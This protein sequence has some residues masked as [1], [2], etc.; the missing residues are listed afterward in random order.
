MNNNALLSSNERQGAKIKMMRALILPKPVH[1]KD[2]VASNKQNTHK[3]D[4][5]T[6]SSLNEHVDAFNFS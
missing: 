3:L 4:I 5:N 1:L 2:V 6:V